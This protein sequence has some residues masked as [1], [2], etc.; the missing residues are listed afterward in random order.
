M[1]TDIPMEVARSRWSQREIEPIKER[2]LLVAAYDALRSYQYGNS[3]TE[4][5]EEM[6]NAIGLYF[7]GGKE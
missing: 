1:R 2:K 4:L 3:S 6:A 5:A 7:S